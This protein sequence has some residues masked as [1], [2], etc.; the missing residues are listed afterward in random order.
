MCIGIMLELCG[1]GGG[2]GE[3]IGSRPSA[4]QTKPVGSRAQWIRDMCRKMSDIRF[5]ACFSQHSSSRYPFP[6]WNAITL[7]KLSVF[8]NNKQ[9]VVFLF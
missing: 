6:I 7:T 9:N 4:H 2:W 5:C 1:G 8:T 3:P